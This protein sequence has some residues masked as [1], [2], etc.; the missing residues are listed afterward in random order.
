MSAGAPGVKH[1]LAGGPGQKT[2]MLPRGLHPEE[3]QP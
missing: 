3:G 1:G 2:R